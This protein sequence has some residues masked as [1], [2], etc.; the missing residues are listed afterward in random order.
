MNARYFA[1]LADTHLNRPGEGNFL[2]SEF[3]S[4]F[5]KAIDYFCTAHQKLDFLV[6]T[7][8]VVHEGDTED[9]RFLKELVQRSEEKLGAPIFITLGNHD[10]R[11]SFYEGYLETAYE[12]AYC[13]S[14]DVE[15]LRLI[16]LDSKIGEHTA[17]GMISEE[18][19][20][21]LREELA[22]PAELGTIIAFH[23]PPAAGTIESAALLLRNADDLL[24]AIRSTDVIGILSGH[25]HSTNQCLLENNIL[26]ATAASTAFGLGGSDSHIIMV[27][28][29]AFNVGIVN[30]KKM[31]IGNIQLPAEPEAVL[32]SFTFEQMAA[33]ATEEFDPEAFAV[34]QD[35]A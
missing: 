20:T 26:S 21:W 13:A 17:Y 30:E 25:T 11:Q 23:H 18:Q 31:H 8:D 15:G 33:L 34:E 22:E 24:D 1:H 27:D 12:D 29:C 35:V 9:Y 5:E 19:L 3:V 2:K 7:G 6:I 4:N 32:A 16:T 14:Y 10:N 28:R